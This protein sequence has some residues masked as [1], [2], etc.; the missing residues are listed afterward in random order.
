MTIRKIRIRNWQIAFYFS[1]DA[2]DIG[3]IKDALLWADAPASVIRDVSE[4]ASSGVLNEG[5]CYSNPRLRKSV[6]GIG[7][8]DT[9]PEF[10]NTAIHEIAHVAMHIAEKD[11]IDPYSE[12]LAYLMGDISHD[13]SPI[14]CEMSCPRCRCE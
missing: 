13:I 8:T 12:K 3:V 7:E 11:G 9:G 5:F 6:V 4:K 2:Y 14:V 1:F 10:L